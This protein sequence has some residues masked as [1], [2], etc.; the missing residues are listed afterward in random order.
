MLSVERNIP[1]HPHTT[2][3]LG[4]PAA[5]WCVCRTVDE[6]REAVHLSRDQQWRLFVLGGGSN[7]VFADEGFPGLV[8]K[9]ELR[10]IDIQDDDDHV[11]ITVAAGEWWDAFV[12]MTVEKGYAGV[13]CLS[14]IP[15]SVGAT[16]IQNVGAYGQEVKDTIVSVTVLDRTSLELH[17]ILSRDCGF[18]YRTSR[19]KTVDAGKH[20]VTGVTFRLKKNGRPTIHYPEVRKVVESSVDLASLSDGSEVLQ[21]LRGVILSL[22]AKKSMVID[23]EDVNSCSVGSFFL[24][25]I[26]DRGALKHVQ[27]VWARIGDGSPVPSFPFGEQVKVPA[28]WL[29]ERAGFKKGYGKDGVAISERHTL[30]LVNRGGTTRALMV[31]AEEIRYG[32][33]K[34]FGLELEREANIIQ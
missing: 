4:G 9:V 18:S 14:G 28:A 15:G 25:P 19:W 26:V 22:R 5:Q 24:N 27:T 32:V 20:I 31:L 1:L 3:R 34:V 33:Q 30:A 11:L 13:E 2:I 10:G 21:V 17:T 29:I 12:Q 7:T 8:A 6:L 23:P 16:P